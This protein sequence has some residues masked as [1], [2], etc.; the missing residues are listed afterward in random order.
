MSG[1]SAAAGKRN[2]QGE[3]KHAQEET[4]SA[5]RKAQGKQAEQHSLFTTNSSYSIRGKK[6]EAVV[7]ENEAE[8]ELL[9]RATKVGEEHQMKGL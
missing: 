9:S 2:D 1:A 8:A 6:L 5:A 3:Q 7:V 4:V